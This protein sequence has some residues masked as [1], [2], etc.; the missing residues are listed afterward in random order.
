MSGNRLSA[1][2]AREYTT[3]MTKARAV[4]STRRPTYSPALLSPL[5]SVTWIVRRR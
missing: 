1:A 2:V 5:V 4:V 3:P